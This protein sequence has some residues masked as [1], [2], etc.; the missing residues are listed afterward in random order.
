[1]T[2]FRDSLIPFDL[3]MGK[4]SHCEA[5][6]GNS[7][8]TFFFRKDHSRSIHGVALGFGADHCPGGLYAVAQH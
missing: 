6:V 5:S 2:A 4:R 1:M 8:P 7:E 3:L